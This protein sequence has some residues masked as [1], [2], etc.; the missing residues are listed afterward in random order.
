LDN[1]HFSRRSRGPIVLMAILLLL[2]GYTLYE[3]QIIN[4]EYWAQRSKTNISSTE[5]VSA[6]RGHI[7]DR[8]GRVMVS[9]RVTY[10]VTLNTSLMGDERNDILSALMDAARAC[11]VEWEDTLPISDHPPFRYTSATPFYTTSTQEDGTVTRSLTRLGKLAVKM[12]WLSGDPT[13]PALDVELPTAE[14]LLGKMCASFSIA[15]EGAVDPKAGQPVPTLNIGDMDPAQARSLAGLLYELYLRSKEITWDSYI[16]A[17]DV[18]I[19]F[20][21]R[22]KEQSLAGVEIKAATARQYHTDYAAHLLGRYTHIYADDWSTYKEID[23]NGDGVG[24]YSM[25]DYVGREGIEQAFEQY[26]RGWSGKRQVSRD[27]SGKI[28]EEVWITQPEPGSHV[29]S[30]LDID[31]QQAVEDILSDAIPALK[32]EDTEGAACVILDVDTAEVLASASYPT[33]NLSTYSADYN[34]T[35]SNPLNPLLNRVTMGLYPPGSTFKM[36]TGIAGLE[37]GIIT[38]KTEIRDTGRYTYYSSNGPQCWIF[39][40]YGGTHGLQ[41]VTEAIKNS[42]NIFFFD[43]GR[44]LGIRTLQE[45]AAKFGLGEYTGIEL[46]EY[47]GTMAGPEYTQAMGGTWYDGNTLSVAIGQESSQFTPLQLANYIATL[48]NGGT[49][50]TPHVLKEVKSS[51]FT[52]VL[53]SYQ[54]QVR[55]T[56]NIDEKNLDAVKKGMLALTTEGSVSSY[57]RDLPVKVGAKT[58]SA[59]VN[60]S[61]ESNAVFVCFAPYDDPQ[62]A[63]ALVV[64]KGGSGSELGKIAAEILKYYFSA[65]ETRDEILTENTLIR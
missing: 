10:Q 26:L 2:L 1:K 8:Y 28:V 30:T 21:S 38:P 62:I 40:Q 56:I 25:D 54:P 13:N 41:N 3:V 32:S 6:A 57:F 33:F 59:Q 48:V 65:E 18:D 44:Q 29:V 31:L 7:L 50:N 4:G 20:I 47:K 55:S 11:G 17:E 39:R 60:A 34:E 63:M 43:V 58:G 23:R 27:T 15:G 61:T 12:K 46:P 53:Y 35:A 42:C 16:F 19:D 45:Y 52:Q 5:Q 64:E 24:D 36:V 22:V 9:N 49:L 14:Q 37:E 51:D